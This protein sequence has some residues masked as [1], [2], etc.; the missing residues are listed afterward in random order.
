MEK[1]GL[2]GQTQKGCNKSSLLDYFFFFFFIFDFIKMNLYAELW[3]SLDKDSL[4]SRQEIAVI[5]N[6]KPVL[7]EFIPTKEGKK[8]FSKRLDSISG[9]TIT[10]IRD[11]IFNQVYPQLW[12]LILKDFSEAEVF[13]RRDET[14]VKLIDSEKKMQE[15]FKNMLERN[16]PENMKKTIDKQRFGEYGG[17]GFGGFEGFSYEGSEIG[18]MYSEEEIDTMKKTAT[19]GTVQQ[20]KETDAWINQIE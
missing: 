16:L 11:I 2:E 4:Y 3:K 10:K 20:Q 18:S 6:I 19:R 14:L 9:L 12:G 13:N 8:L 17:Y 7:L 5:R 15:Y 1:H